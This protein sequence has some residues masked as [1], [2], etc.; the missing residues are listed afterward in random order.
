MKVK[1]IIKTEVQ[2][3]LKSRNMKDLWRGVNTICGR[4]TNQAEALKLNI[5]NSTSTTADEKECANIFANTF[6][7][8]VDK[9]VQQVGTKD[10]LTKNISKKLY[11]V[12]PRLQFS[13]QD[14]TK[15][16]QGF[17][18]SSSCGPDGI[19]INYIK[20]MIVPLAPIL[21]FLFDKA[22]FHAKSPLQWK[23][24][25]IVPIHKKGVK[26]DPENYRPISLLCSLGK[27]YEKC[28]LKV[29]DDNFSHSIPSSFQHGF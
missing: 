21:K 4:N 23:T 6:K 27:V 9:L 20:D 15:A 22:A 5:P 29:M 3:M 12:Q 19:P 10:A 14:I 2:R 1:I 26:E 17:K 28:I 8:K 11:T 13:I 25:K 24:A 18:Q 16:V 7:T